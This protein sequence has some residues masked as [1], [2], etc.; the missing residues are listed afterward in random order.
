MSEES[1]SDQFEDSTDDLS[2]TRGTMESVLQPPPPFLFENN[3][4]NVTSGNL[5]AEWQKWQKS[6][7][8]Y[9][10][11]CEISKKSK[12]V[13][14]NILLHIIGDKCREVYEQF[15]EEVQ[16]VEELLRKFD[17]FFIPKKNLAVERHK[18]FNRNQKE[19]ESTEQYVFEL[20]KIAAKCE[21]KDLQDDLV[22]SRFICGVKDVGLSER[23]LR[24]PDIT[25]KKALEICRLSEIS[26]MQA[27][28][29]KTEEHGRHI[30]EICNN[31]N[32][33][34]PETGDVHLV[35]R[36]PALSHARRP[37]LTQSRANTNSGAR[38]KLVYRNNYVS[39]FSKQFP[40]STNINTHNSPPGSTANDHGRLITSCGNCGRAHRR[41]QC[42]AYGV[43]CD[44]CNRMNHYARMCRSV[45]RVYTLQEDS[46]DQVIS[47]I[48]NSDSDWTVKLKLNNYWVRFKLDTGADVNVLPK[49]FLNSI[50][51]KDSDLTKTSIKLQGY[52]GGNIIV[53]GK[54]FLKVNYKE[55]IYFL[56]FIIADVDS[57]PVLGRS[58]CEE[59]NL[60]KRIM[61]KQI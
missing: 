13:Q 55:G 16:T 42:P 28:N 36:R 10:E 35:N 26:R 27:Q 20:N 11:A 18:F 37:P 4:S 40:A 33:I 9:F 21:F 25:L 3:L 43:R 53:I 19:F 41:L 51:L 15:T 14:I 31:N 60:L 58:S 59:L 56:N 44:N 29:M 47:Q 57:P 34:E 2:V 12:K 45:R 54:C 24:E 5:S 17:D 32:R 6:F 50:G 46:T 48:N 8:I 38:E 23:L 30:H 52:S 61:C 49:R 22:C 1:E 39:S 7:K